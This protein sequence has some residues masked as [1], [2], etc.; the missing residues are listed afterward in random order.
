MLLKSYS[1]NYIDL[2][3]K[4]LLIN[5]VVFILIKL[6]S[7]IRSVKRYQTFAQKKG[8][9]LFGNL[10]EVLPIFG[11]K[12]H[13]VRSTLERYAKDFGQIG[14]GV[15]W[16]S[17]FPVIGVIDYQRT[18]EILAKPSILEKGFPFEYLRYF[19]GDGILCSSASKWKER[20]RMIR[21]KFTAASVSN[22]VPTVT[23]KGQ[24]LLKKLESVEGTCVDVTKFVS[25]TS[26][27]ILIKIT[28]ATDVDEERLVSLDESLKCFIKGTLFRTINPF[29]WPDWSHSLYGCLTGLNSKIE[30][31][32]LLVKEAILNYLVSKTESQPENGKFVYRAALDES[33]MVYLFDQILNET[34][35]VDQAIEAT[36]EEMKT[37]FIAGYDG[38][39]N[40]LVWLIYVL[41]L[42]NDVQEKIY[43][44][45]ADFDE[46]LVDLDVI[47]QWTYTE[48]CVKE[49]LRLF[50]P[51]PFAS[52][53]VTEDEPFNDK[54][55]P[56]GAFIFFSIYSIHR[57][58]RIYSNATKFDP[59]RFE[60][61]NAS[62][63]PS[64]S[65]IPFGLR[66]RD[67][68]GQRFA[69]VQM[70]LLVALL[71]KHFQI[72][73]TKPFEEIGQEI[74]FTLKPTEP[75]YAFFNKRKNELYFS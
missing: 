23:L 57:D 66:P 38:P 48:Q 17:W 20:K 3:I 16:L 28:L 26:L 29:L 36:V 14:Y 72:K 1:T 74:D 5:F 62:S 9:I 7:L 15:F 46:H 73:S 35:S 22:F 42:N 61:S 25:L 4:I 67:C 24:L 19:I 51:A 40:A 65:Y 10:F 52:R 21:P 56:K 43:Q 58:E 45:V 30:Q 75:L 64:G 13:L 69:M 59:D 47:K 50:P 6:I 41:G 31:V 53:L 27:S 37:L 18:Q 49:I 68:I 12:T 63:L 60:Q 33:I 55:L 71:V 39:N 32:D 8:N 34:E 2:L 70:K 44:E 54:V 11:D